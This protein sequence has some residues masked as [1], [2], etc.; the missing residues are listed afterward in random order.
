M[1]CPL[2]APILND[3]Q[4]RG[5]DPQFGLG[6]PGGP[7][8]DAIVTA[9]VATTVNAA[10][11][12]I[13]IA[14]ISSIFPSLE[15]QVQFELQRNNGR[16]IATRIRTQIE[17]CAVRDLGPVGRGARKADDLENLWNRNGDFLARELVLAEQAVLLNIPDTRLARDGFNAW[18]RVM[19][20]YVECMEDSISNGI[21]CS[22]PNMR[23]KRCRI[24]AM[25]KRC[26]R[27]EDES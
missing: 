10:L 27:F 22:D 3:L 2:E 23:P 25:V 13:G 16:D 17:S 12:A 8:T 11:E 14:P 19:E 18:I 4:E 7:L 26:V 6:T 24:P 15:T 9:L 5:L 21:Q 20:D 1:S